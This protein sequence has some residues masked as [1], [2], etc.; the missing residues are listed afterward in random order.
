MT[1]W[2][3]TFADGTVLKLLEVGLSVEDVWKLSEVH[4][5]ASVTLSEV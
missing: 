2:V 1:V 3:Y 5:R 4:G